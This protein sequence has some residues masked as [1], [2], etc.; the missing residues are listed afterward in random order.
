M[1]RLQRR[2]HEQARTIGVI[3]RYL[4]IAALI[5]G[6]APVIARSAAAQGMTQ[7]Q[8]AAILEELKQIRLLLERNLRHES[9]HV[10]PPAPA[11]DREVTL[12]AVEAYELGR[13]DAPLTLVEFTDYECSFCRQYHISTFEQLKRNYIDTGKLRYVS[14]DFPLDFHKL[15]FGAANAA[16][17]AGEQGKYWELRHAVRS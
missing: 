16:R 5:L 14:R 12:P 2:G 10:T 1:S 4:T 17:C 13:S 9:A 11:P 15:A 3:K 6:L 8:A 7:E